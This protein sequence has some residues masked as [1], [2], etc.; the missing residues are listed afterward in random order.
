MRKRGFKRLQYLI[1]ET[2]DI[3]MQSPLRLGEAPVGSQVRTGDS[4]VLAPLTHSPV[5]VSSTQPRLRLL[6]VLH[7]LSVEE[8]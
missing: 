4:L 1:V 6:R 7:R 3:Q 5:V 2:Q 8:F